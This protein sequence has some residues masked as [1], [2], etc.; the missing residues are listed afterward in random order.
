MNVPVLTEYTDF[1]TAVRR[2]NIIAVKTSG[3]SF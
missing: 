3:V 1:M 2:G